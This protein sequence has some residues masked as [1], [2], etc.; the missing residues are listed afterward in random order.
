MSDSENTNAAKKKRARPEKEEK[1]NS[2]NEAIKSELETQVKYLA[3]KNCQ[4]LGSAEQ[5]L[6]REERAVAELTTIID[7]VIR[8]FEHWKMSNFTRLFSNRQVSNQNL[9]E[10]DETY[11]GDALEFVDDMDSFDS[12]ATSSA[13]ADMTHANNN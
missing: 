11:I 12:E 6:D 8:D 4:A 9:S 3:Q 5:F 10:D 1:M 7:T 2:Q 13:S